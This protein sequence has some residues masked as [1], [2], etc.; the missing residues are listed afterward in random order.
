MLLGKLNIHVQKNEIEHL[1]YTINKN[2][3]KLE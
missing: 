2:Q 1:P 3:S